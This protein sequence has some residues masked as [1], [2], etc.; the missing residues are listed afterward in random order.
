MPCFASQVSLPGFRHFPWP[1]CLKLD[2]QNPKN[3]EGRLVP[4][5]EEPMELL[6]EMPG[7]C[8]TQKFLPSKANLKFVAKRG[9]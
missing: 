9:L 6:K 4:L 8:Q 5:N 1:N 3:N 7:V 2:P